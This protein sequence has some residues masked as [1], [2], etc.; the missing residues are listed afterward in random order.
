MPG[1]RT[2]LSWMI[3]RS[4]LGRAVTRL[5][6]SRRLSGEGYA[7]LVLNY[8]RIGPSADS[9][10][11]RGCFSATADEFAEHLRYLKR[12]CSLIG[13]EDLASLVDPT[14]PR[15]PKRPVLLTFDD[16][17]ADNY[18]LAFPLLRDA[19]VRA[20]FF[21]TTAFIDRTAVAWWDEIA[22]LVRRLPGERATFSAFD[23]SLPL[24]GAPWTDEGPPNDRSPLEPRGEAIRRTLERYKRL[25]AGEAAALLKTLREAVGHD[26]PADVLS[27][28]YMTWP[29]LREMQ[30]AG[31]SIGGHT[32]T[33]PVLASLSEAEQ[34]AEIVG[35]RDRL[36]EHLGQSPTAFSYPVG[37]PGT[38]TETTERLVREAG[39][40]WGFQF[41]GGLWRLGTDRLARTSRLTIP[42]LPVTHQAT[43]HEFRTQVSWPRL[44]ED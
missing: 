17:Y 34:R 3:D 4:R 27:D 2:L 29:Q 40:E 25:P 28:L 42:R 38:F 23:L 32:L 41:F 7:V 35:C 39:F 24:P 8:H 44:F 31:M 9:P 16:G 1:K 21:P 15:P 10:F 14:S 43:A 22:W 18:H 20:A 33:H 13:L 26:C 19:G 30:A 5:S 6:W 36:H 37:R 11:D 12:R